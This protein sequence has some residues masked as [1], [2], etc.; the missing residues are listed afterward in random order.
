MLRYMFPALCL[1]LAA[2]GNSLE[3]PRCVNNVE[4]GLGVCVAGQCVAADAQ[5]DDGVDVGDDTVADVPDGASDDA[6]DDA[7]VDTAPDVGVD[8]EDDT[9]DV[10]GD[11][12]ADDVATD[13]PVDTATDTAVD[14]ANDTATDAPVDTATDAPVDTATDTPLDTPTDT[15]P[16]LCEPDATTCAGASLL[17]CSDDGSRWVEDRICPAGCAD[18]ACVDPC[19]AATGYAGCLFFAVDLDN[20]AQPCSGTAACGIGGSCID[21]F[22]SPSAASQPFEITVSNTWSA[23]ATVSLFRGASNAA[24]RTVEVPA[25]GVRLLGDLP[26]RDLDGSELSDDTWRI[27]SSVPI[28]VHQFNPA[29]NAA[30]VYSSDA[31]MLLP[32]ERLGREYL[33]LSWPALG[34]PITG[35]YGQSYVAIIA[36]EPGTTTVTVTSP[37]ATVA[38]ATGPPRALSPARPTEFELTYGQVLSFAANEGD[39]DVTGFEVSASQSVA[40]FAGTEC[41]TVPVGVGFC[42]HLEQQMLPTSMWGTS[43]VGARFAPRGTAPDVWRVLGSADGTTLTVSPTSAAPALSGRTISR[44]EV[45]EFRSRADFMLT[46]SAPVALGQYM[47]GSQYPAD[48]T[49]TCERGGL[50]GGDVNCA[51]PNSCPSGSG[52]G[53]PAFVL[54][55]PSER[56]RDNYVV[57]VPTTYPSDYLTIV[58]PVGA[59]VTLDG[60]PPT[61]AADIVGGWRIWRE[62]VGDGIHQVLGD[63]PFGLYVYGYDC[64]VS[65]AYPG[66]LNLDPL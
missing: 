3:S 61:T 2:C 26:R 35:T 51:I 41:S 24:E 10:A 64:D 23:P 14:T 45:V 39:L 57:P 13:T 27:E 50:L 47:V 60:A 43:Y 63:E 19:D 65:Y 44:G 52:I 4:C 20:F 54:A 49:G 12:A 56:F 17:Q 46:A 36:T 22:C 37:V 7:L 33:A 38:G 42:D 32:A 34:G 55:I 40:V 5:G 11:D 53:D 66:G 62:P 29:N 8:A 59:T 30:E 15:P 1:M 6:A 21:G 31:S 18:G 58:A 28:T 25:R 16:P 9:A 48:D